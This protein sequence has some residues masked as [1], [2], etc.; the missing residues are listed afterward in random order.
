MEPEPADGKRL[1][2]HIHGVQELLD[3]RSR[4]RRA[5]RR[6]RGLLLVPHGVDFFVHEG[7]FTPPFAGTQRPM[8]VNTALAESYKNECTIGQVGSVSS[9]AGPAS[10]KSFPCFLQKNTKQN[11]KRP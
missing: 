7:L 1:D 11:R 9:N 5:A 3:K 8:G 4:Q 2:P 10:S 6:H